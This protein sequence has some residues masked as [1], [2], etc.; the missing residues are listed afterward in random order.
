M[1]TLTSN[2]YIHQEEDVISQFLNDYPSQNNSIDNEF[3]IIGVD[4]R[5]RITQ[6]TL[7]PFR[8]VCHVEITR[9]GVKEKGRTGVLIGPK[10]VLTA[11]HC[12]WDESVDRLEDLSKVS[13]RVIPG[14]NG[15]L[16]PLSA[17]RA[18][19]LVASPGY[20]K[21]KGASKADY[22]IIHLND[23]IGNNI[24]YWS[25]KYRK[26]KADTLGTSTLS[27]N[28][29][30]APGKLFVNLCGYPTDKS[31]QQQYSSYGKT[32]LNKDGMLHYLNDTY[33]GHSG[34]PVWIK[35]A[36]SMGGRVLVGIH[37]A[38]DDAIGV[39]ANRAV[40]INTQVRNFIITNLK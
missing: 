14:R 29:P 39:K 13:I 8:Y 34:S 22:G 18:V 16:Q 38:G 31:G 37:V 33:F 20:N 10:T 15:S 40:F 5:K 3:E 11:A 12:I 24:G 17:S 4:E 1:E 36:A 2:N 19:K 9:N 7:A 30:V 26:T 25:L 28:L 32:V 35:R 6:T 27:G 23:P 21:S